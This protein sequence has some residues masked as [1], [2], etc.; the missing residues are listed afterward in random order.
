[1]TTL[2]ELTALLGFIETTDLQ[3]LRVQVTQSLIMSP[4]NLSLLAEYHDAAIRMVEQLSPNDYT[5]A[6]IGLIVQLAAIKWAA[7]HLRI[8]AI[9]DLMDAIEYA[10]NAQLNEWEVIQAVMNELITSV[11]T[12]SPGIAVAAAFRTLSRE[13]QADIAALQAAE[14]IGYAFTCLIENGLAD[15]E[16][17]LQDRGILG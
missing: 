5:R 3:H 4:E 8:R 9:E 11:A 17:Y 16:A 1:M 14:A 10:W 12:E 2:E 15:P 7:P 6:Q 13:D